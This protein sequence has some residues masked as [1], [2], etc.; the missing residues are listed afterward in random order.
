MISIA[1]LALTTASC[2]YYAYAKRFSW[3]PGSIIRLI[4]NLNSEVRMLNLQ[5]QACKDLTNKKNKNLSPLSDGEKRRILHLIN[6]QT[7]RLLKKA[8]SQK[9][10]FA[11]VTWCGTN[12]LPNHQFGD[13]HVNLEKEQKKMNETPQ[14]FMRQ[15]SLRTSPARIVYECLKLKGYLVKLKSLRKEYRNIDANQLTLEGAF[16]ATM[17]R[18]QSLDHEIKYLARDTTFMGWARYG[19]VGP[20]PPSYRP[21]YQRIF[22]GYRWDIVIAA[23]EDHER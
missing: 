8:R 16:E 18:Y 23:D 15:F 21:R 6:V 7:P 12:Q 22:S 10:N 20:P 1:V 13:E 11:V 5:D 17:T 2:V 3:L 9:Q 19:P 14:Q 4:W